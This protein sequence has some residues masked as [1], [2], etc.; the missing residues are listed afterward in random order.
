MSGDW[1]C[2]L[3][4]D[5]GKNQR[6]GPPQAPYCRKRNLSKGH[7]GASK[8]KNWIEHTNASAS[9]YQECNVD[10][11]KS[12]EGNQQRLPA[13]LFFVQGLHILKLQAQP[14]T[15]LDLLYAIGVCVGAE[16]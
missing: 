3:Y 1:E 4:Q 9:H 15:S 10:E 6:D 11:W 5:L 2:L 8:P 14:S 13:A 12:P 16:R 7:V